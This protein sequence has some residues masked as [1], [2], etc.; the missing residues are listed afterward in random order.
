MDQSFVDAEKVPDL[1]E[2]PSVTLLTQSDRQRFI[3]AEM[4]K[5]SQIDIYVLI[6]FIKA[7]NIEPNWMHMQL[8]LGITA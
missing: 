8:P 5:T 7:Q 1:F 6:D 2:A 3:L 4:I